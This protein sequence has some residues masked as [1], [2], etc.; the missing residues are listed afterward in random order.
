[1]ATF[2][3]ISRQKLALINRQCGFQR[4]FCSA[5]V[6]A[7]LKPEITLDES[8]S[9]ALDAGQ[10]KPRKHEGRLTT[11]GCVTVPGPIVAAIV[12]SCKDHPVKALLAEGRKLDN[13]VRSRKPPMEPDELRRRIN[14]V[15][16]RV[17]EEFRGKVAVEEMSEE[18]ITYINKVVEA[19][20]KKRAKQQIYAW[21]PVDYDAFKGLQYLLGRS[22]A[23]YAVL[24]RIFEE[25]KKRDPGFKP[26]SLIDFGAGVGTGTW[27]AS[28]LWKEH[29]FEYVSIDAS[30]DMNDLAELILRGGD[31]NKP[32]TLR[33]VFYRQFLPATSKSKYDLVMA[34]F[35]LFEL[36]SARNRLD[37][38]G[39][40]WD[41]CDGYLV[42][43][44]HGSYAGFSLI[45]EARRFLLKK[46][47][48][49][50][51]EE[52]H[53]FSPCPHEQ[54]CPRV[55]LDD[56]TPC[57]FEMTYNQL[58][59]CGT[60]GEAAK[61]V[62]SYVVFKKGPPSAE[63]SRF[64]RLVRPTL[65]RS[66]HAVCRMCTDAGKLQEVIFTASKHGKNLY[67]CAK[68]TKW[69]DQ[70]PIKIEEKS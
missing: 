42:L 33:N 5:G 37:I 36:P 20:S 55:T 2:G 4:L 52:L 15:R 61:C 10:Y 11:G 34:A 9:Q 43:V 7:K 51:G 48:D 35:S 50:E 60:A 39:N 18:Q 17:G 25:I 24:T 46:V 23:E 70:L 59:L 31:V 1:M 47:E 29:I 57:N 67:R 40:L 63:Q 54:S 58:P 3:L 13:F 32:M 8:I 44:E 30:A 12:K 53:V 19:Q 62:Y 16:H 21:K 38:V 66:K 26:R 14:E 64:P 56:G 68:A 69:G 49:G 41:K 27:A 22:A 45:E 65:A 28:N 6:T